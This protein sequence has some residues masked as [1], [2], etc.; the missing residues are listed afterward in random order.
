MGR[1]IGEADADIA[2]HGRIRRCFE[3]FRERRAAKAA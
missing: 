2:R 3:D 1:T